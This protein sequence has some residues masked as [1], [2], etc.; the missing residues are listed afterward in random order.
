M[1]SPGDLVTLRG[2]TNYPIELHDF[3]PQPMIGMRHTHTTRLI[4]TLTSGVVLSH[5]LFAS[6]N[7]VPTPGVYLDLREFFRI[8]TPHGIGYVENADFNECVMVVNTTAH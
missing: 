2:S 6:L 3:V 1:L 8:A 7:D 5:R 4:I